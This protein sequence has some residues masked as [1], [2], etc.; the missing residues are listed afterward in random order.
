MKT[1]EYF[2]GGNTY[3]CRIVQANNGEELV[4]APTT[5]LDVIQSGSFENVK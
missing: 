4:I 5:L 1:K 3:V 2:F